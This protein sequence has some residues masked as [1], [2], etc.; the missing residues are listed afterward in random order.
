MALA[1]QSLQ[2]YTAL[3]P[4]GLHRENN[5]TIAIDILY[6]PR[7]C[8]HGMEKRT[9]NVTNAAICKEIE[10]SKPKVTALDKA[11]DSAIGHTGEWI[12]GNL[13]GKRPNAV[14]ADH[15]EVK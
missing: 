11:R 4:S 5:S 15:A 13:F 12:C 7:Y 3:R 8:T 10:V 2:V 1:R 6:A 9:T 14:I